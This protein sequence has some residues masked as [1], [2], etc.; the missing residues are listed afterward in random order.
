MESFNQSDDRLDKLL[1]LIV[2]RTCSLKG[3]KH[4]HSMIA[5]KTDE[6]ITTQ[7][8]EQSIIVGALKT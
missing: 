3:S 6:A 8:I 4:R 5:E 7:L 1:P 2:S